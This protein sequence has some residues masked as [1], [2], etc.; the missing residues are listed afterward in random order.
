[1][2]CVQFYWTRAI[3]QKTLFATK[4]SVWPSGTLRTVDLGYR[5][6]LSVAWIVRFWFKILQRL[7]V[8]A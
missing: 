5:S 6:S 3:S 4:H 2:R 8:Y 7:T 1:M